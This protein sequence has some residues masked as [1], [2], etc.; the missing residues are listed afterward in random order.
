VA[1]AFIWR[2]RPEI[3]STAEVARRTG[4]DQAVI[5]RLEGGKHQP[6]LDTLRR[7]ADALGLGVAELLSEASRGAT[8]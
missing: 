2:L 6:R 1:D 5:S 4:L 8:K 7:I 3:A